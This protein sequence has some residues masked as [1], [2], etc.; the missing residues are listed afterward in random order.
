M[1]IA[2][3]RSRASVKTLVRSDSVAGM[4]SAAPT[5][6]TARAAIELTDA[7][8]NA[9]AADATP[10]TTRPTSSVRRAAVA[11]AERAREEQQTGEHEGVRVDDPLQLADARAELA[12]RAWAARR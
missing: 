10:N 9:A 6:I 1:P 2:M 5:P 8:A 7:A 12:R 3:A 4:M 11:V